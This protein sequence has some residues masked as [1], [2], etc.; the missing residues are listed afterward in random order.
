M[1]GKIYVGVGGW[2]YEPWRGTYYPN[3]LKQKDELSF[4]A[5]NT[6]S[7]ETLCGALH[8]LSR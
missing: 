6:S 8:F 3:G 7:I 5:Q 4:M 2:T 1:G